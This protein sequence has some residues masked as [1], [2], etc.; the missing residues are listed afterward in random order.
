[1]ETAQFDDFVVFL[2]RLRLK[3][4]E[5]LVPLLAFRRPDRRGLHGVGIFV[6]LAQPLFGHEFGIATEQNIGTA[7][8]HVG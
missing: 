4:G 7:A 8:G 1:M 6:L 2:L 3:P 5:N